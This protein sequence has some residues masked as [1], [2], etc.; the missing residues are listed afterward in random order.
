MIK[1]N[2]LKFLYKRSP[3]NFYIHSEGNTIIKSINNTF[4]GYKYNKEFTQEDIY[5]IWQ[6]IKC[7]KQFSTMTVFLLFLIL[8]YCVL[9][10]NYKFLVDS[11]PLVAVIIFLI[12]VFLIYFGISFLNTKLF[13]KSLK[14]KFGEYEK[15]KFI[16]SD[17]IDLKYYKI[18]KTELLKA[19]GLILAVILCISLVSPFRLASRWTQQKK[20]NSVIKITTIGSKV[21]PIAPEW[22]SLRGY[23]HFQLGDYQ[24][25]IEDYDRAYRLG[26]D[27]YKIMNFDNKIFIKYYIK[28]YKGALKD[29]DTEI[30]N[31]KTQYE[32]DSFMWDKAQFLYNIK[33]YKKALKVYNDLL[34]QAEEDRIFLLKNRLFFERAQ[35]YKKLGME[36]LAQKDLINAE[37]DNIEDPFKNPIPE[38]NLLQDSF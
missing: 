37:Y 17:T 1:F 10:P 33:E 24:K 18:F 9:F 19:I 35:V 22:Y 29:F 28:D 12:T 5:S 26:T 11:N 30:K 13:E 25:A 15:T 23:S 16:S 14:N 2:I 20:Y 32:K 6:C 8:L 7:H 21:F 4:C 36:D 38:P 31:V 34:I 3:M 27:D